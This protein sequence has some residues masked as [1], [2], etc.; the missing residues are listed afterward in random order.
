M[1]LDST[2]WLLNS[3][4]FRQNGL[5]FKKNDTSF[6]NYFQIEQIYDPKDLLDS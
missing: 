6:D 1:L 3:L 2:L 5:F 4:L